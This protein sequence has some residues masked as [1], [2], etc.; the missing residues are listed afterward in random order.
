[1]EVIR[2]GKRREK[3]REEAAEESWR[4]I[5]QERENR[6]EW[7]MGRQEKENKYWKRNDRVDK[8][9]TLVIEVVKRL[10]TSVESCN[11]MRC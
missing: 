4:R 7:K 11:K 5:E 6:Y 1:M 9:G 3:I 2:R 10:V 8:L